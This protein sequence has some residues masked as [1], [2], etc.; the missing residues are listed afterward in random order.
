M[1]RFTKSL[2]FFYYNDMDYYN[3][4]ERRDFRQMGDEVTTSSIQCI[5]KPGIMEGY[6]PGGLPPG[7]GT[8]QGPRT[9]EENRTETGIRFAV[10][11][12]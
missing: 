2:P 8:N 6:T 11:E 9:P 12:V 5:K 3:D 7:G 10:I 1:M 4:M